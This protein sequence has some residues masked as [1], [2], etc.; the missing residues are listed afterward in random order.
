MR[1]TPLLTFAFASLAVG[2]FAACSGTTSSSNT[3][4][5]SSALSSAQC[6]NKDFE[7]AQEDCFT[8]ATADGS[9][10]ADELAACLP[11]PKGGKGG[12]GGPP[13]QGGPGGHGD[14]DGGPPPPPS[15]SAPPP[16]P[17]GSAPPPGGHGPDGD[18]DH[19]GGPGGGHHG[20]HP[21]P[22]ALEACHDALASC[23][24]AGTDAKTCFDAART[25]MKDAFKA[26]FDAACADA[27]TKCDAGE[28]P[29]D[30]CTEITARCA[31]GPAP[32]D[33][34]PGAPTCK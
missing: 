27:K 18:G 12:P 22:A 10:T 23:V 9:A 7:A 1:T 32:K 16:P 6:S 20:P 19:G 4:D 15:G 33:G 13:G 11:P 17:S 30:K 25:C 21:D 24:G 5:V 34:A 3:E 14:C 28:I 31:A 26:A 8:K 29:A 2:A